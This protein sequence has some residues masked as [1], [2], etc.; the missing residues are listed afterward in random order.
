MLTDNFVIKNLHKYFFLLAG[1][2][3]LVHIVVPHHHHTDEIFIQE[4]GHE[5]HHHDGDVLDEQMISAATAQQDVDLQS[6]VCCCVPSNP[7]FF[8]FFPY[9]VAAK[10]HSLFNA[11]SETVY[12]FVVCSS[13]GLRA[14]PVC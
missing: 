1:L 3:V 7:G 8:S 2:F 4:V 12:S 14:P 5:Q 6:D 10:S 9:A 13:G 11:Y